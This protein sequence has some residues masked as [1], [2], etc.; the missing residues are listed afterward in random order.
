MVGT[1]LGFR[2]STYRFLSVLKIFHIGTLFMYPPYF[3]PNL[4]RLYSVSLLAEIQ[5]HTSDTTPRIAASADWN[6]KTKATDQIA[7]PRVIGWRTIPYTPL[8]TKAVVAVGSALSG[9]PS[10]FKA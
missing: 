6:T 9:L 4:L 2:L 1:N 10:D 7:I 3:S 8:S 5:K